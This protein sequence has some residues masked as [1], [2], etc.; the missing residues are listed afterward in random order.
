MLDQ[1][2]TPAYIAPE[3]L[4]DNGYTGY[5]IDIWSAGVVLYAMLYGTVPFKAHN[6]KELHRSIILA[7]YSLKEGI[8][9]MAMDLIKKILEPNPSQRLSIKQ[10]LAHPWFEEVNED[11]ELF[12]DQEKEKILR[13]FTYNNTDKYNRNT[14][15]VNLSRDD[16]SNS[17]T[18]VESFTEHNLSTQNSLVRNHSTKS[19][20]LA[21]FNST[22]SEIDQ[23]T[24]MFI[25]KFMADRKSL[26]FHA[27]CRDVNRQYEQNNN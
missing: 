16:A 13:E 12:N 21:P 3:I 20:I 19:V 18:T 22:I 14:D 5:G 2:G 8:S 9:E 1:C 15:N 27:R 11:I 10:I 23:E 4:L 25:K 6:M 26:K 7:K 24:K 17:G